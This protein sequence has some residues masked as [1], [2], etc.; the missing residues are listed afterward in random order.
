MPVVYRSTRMQQTYISTTKGRKLIEANPVNAG[1]EPE[2]TLG[3][4]KKITQ[5]EVR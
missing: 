4:A 3:Q 2:L 5:V 1:P